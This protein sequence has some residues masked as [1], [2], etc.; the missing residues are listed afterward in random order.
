VV[1]R[2][3]DGEIPLI[4]TL[5]IGGCGLRRQVRR[6][7]LVLFVALHRLLPL[8]A[9]FATTPAR[10]AREQG[11]FVR[12]GRY[13]F[14]LVHA[15]D[16]ITQ[17]MIRERDRWQRTSWSEARAF[18]AERLEALIDQHGAD[19]IGVLAELLRAGTTA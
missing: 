14:A 10:R 17:P 19:S 11:A 8:R 6:R 7:G 12:Q 1:V 3:D 18:V 2:D 5:I 13:A 9:H 15:E 16:P 4:A